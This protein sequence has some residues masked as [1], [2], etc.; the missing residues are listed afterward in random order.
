M[1]EYSLNWLYFDNAPLNVSDL[2]QH[3]VKFDQN[4]CWDLVEFCQIHVWSAYLYNSRS[5]YHVSASPF[6]K[7]HQN[8]RVGKSNVKDKLYCVRKKIS[9]IQIFFAVE[10]T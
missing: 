3:K 6:F 7:K 5:H 2:Q 1:K 4:G 9:E 10:I 8:L